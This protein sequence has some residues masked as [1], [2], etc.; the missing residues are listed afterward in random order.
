LYTGS[1]FIYTHILYTHAHVTHA[2]LLLTAEISGLHYRRH[3]RLYR[4][5]L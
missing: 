3:D 4:K 1:S 5:F 2:S